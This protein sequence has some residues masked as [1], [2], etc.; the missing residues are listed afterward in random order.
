MQHDIRSKQFPAFH[1]FQF[2]VK[3]KLC[4]HTAPVTSLDAQYVPLGAENSQG[5]QQ[6]RTVVVS[7]S[8]D[9]TVKIWKREP[10]K[11]GMTK[12]K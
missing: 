4:G 11:G 12:N 6:C 8:V 1:S 2:K 3:Q 7:S 10:D 5:T 9:S